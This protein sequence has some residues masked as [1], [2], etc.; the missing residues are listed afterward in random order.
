MKAHLTLSAREFYEGADAQSIAANPQKQ[1]GK[2][3]QFCETKG[4]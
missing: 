2:Q 3:N 1:C 4:R